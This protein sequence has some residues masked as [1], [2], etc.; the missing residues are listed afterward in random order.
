MLFVKSIIKIKIYIVHSVASITLYLL[1]N[2]LESIRISAV[3]LH[4]FLPDTAEK[5]FAYLTLF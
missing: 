2:L 3:L 1:Y 4:S 5:M